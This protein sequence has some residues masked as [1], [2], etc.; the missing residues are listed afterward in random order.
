MRTELYD[1]IIVGSGAGGAAAAWQLTQCGQRVLLIEKG[2]A[3]APSVDTLDPAIVIGEGRYK[4]REQWVD[5]AGRHIVPEEYFNLGGKTKWYGAALMRCA[6]HEIA[7]DPGYDCPAWPIDHA[8]LAPWYTEAERLLGVHRFACEPDLAL[9]ARGL[10]RHGGW[11]AAALPMGLAPDILEH[12]HEASHFDGFASARGLKADAE[13]RL[14][15]HARE[16][17]RLT[18][19]TGM[20]VAAL[21]AANDDARQVNGVLLADGRSLR[22]GRVLLA[23]GALHSPRLLASYL[24]RHG[25][26][27]L[28]VRGNVGRFLKLHLLTALVAITGRPQRDRLRKTTAFTHAD[29]PHSSVQ[30][31]GFDGDLIARLVPRV[32]PRPLARALGARAY[33][34]FLQTEDGSHRDNRIDVSASGLP[35]LDYDARRCPAAVAE[36]AR[37]TRRLRRDLLRAGY[38]SFAERIGI[39]GTAHACGTLAAGD[40]P[41]CS[42]V[43]AAGRVHGMRGL[44]VVDGSVLV[45]SSRVNPSLTIF[46]WSLYVAAR[47][48]ADQRRAA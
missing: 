32:V 11:Q 30:P 37:L 6:P 19:L 27:Q 8:T 47:L 48:A 24:D 29:C 36:H 43:D 25:L 45:R 34:F 15:A 10:Q 26:T 3:I 12:P 44:Y 33:G 7:A 9:I 41:A 2:P 39:T 1:S 20:P 23:A 38:V 18:I 46:A 35:L 17:E 40:D 13:I 28:P 42:V 4:S 31:L 16:S 14:I 22:A 5:G 21:L